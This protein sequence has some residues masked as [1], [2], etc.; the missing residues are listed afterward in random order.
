M[1]EEE[2]QTGEPQGPDKLPDPQNL[3]TDLPPE[4]LQTYQELLAIK[5]KAYTVD[6]VAAYELI[7]AALRQLQ[8]ANPAINDTRLYHMLIGP[9]TGEIPREFDVPGNGIEIFVRTELAKLAQGK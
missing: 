9:G 1:S 5:E 7:T 8:Q 4:K 2:S 6:D 3:E